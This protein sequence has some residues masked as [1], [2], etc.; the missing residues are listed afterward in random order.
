M[1]LDTPWGG[2]REGE[3][4]KGEEEGEWREVGGT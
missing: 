2:E 3:I 4:E 1:C